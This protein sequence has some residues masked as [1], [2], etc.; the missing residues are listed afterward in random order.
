[1]E[2]V[3]VDI[4]LKFYYKIY[5]DQT[6]HGFFALV[7]C[8]MQQQWVAQ[9]VVFLGGRFEGSKQCV[10]TSVGSPTFLVQTVFTF[11][12]QFT[13]PDYHI[14]NLCWLAVHILMMRCLWHSMLTDWILND[15]FEM[16][17]TRILYRLVKRFSTT[18]IKI[19][20]CAK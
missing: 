6:G 17:K 16:Y 8:Q 10:C 14:Q 5:H 7:L 11:S 4:F 2:K 12:P 13:I 15:V 1:M 19:W 9:G 20:K 18:C 3:H